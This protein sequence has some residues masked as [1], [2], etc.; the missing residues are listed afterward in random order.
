MPQIRENKT[1]TNKQ[2]IQLGFNCFLPAWILLFSSRKT[3]A[4]APAPIST[5]T[6]YLLP[7]LP[8]TETLGNRSSFGTSICLSNLVETGQFCAVGSGTRERG[9]HKPRHRQCNHANLISLG[10]R[11]KLVRPR[12]WRWS[13]TGMAVGMPEHPAGDRHSFWLRNG[14]SSC[15]AQCCCSSSSHPWQQPCTPLAVCAP[16]PPVREREIK[17]SFLILQG[18]AKTFLP[19]VKYVRSLDE[20]GYKRPRLSTIA[21][22]PCVMN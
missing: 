4:A 7:S 20:K 6:S 9:T 14:V 1:P 18:I 16:V 3:Q 10:N 12:N 11:A 22:G 19:H 8:C 21:A 17:T 13:N 2:G 15:P 5:L